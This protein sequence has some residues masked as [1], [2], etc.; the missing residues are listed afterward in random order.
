MNQE[1]HCARE[2]ALS[3][4]KPS[5][6]DIDHGMELH[7][8]AVVI[9]AYGFLPFGPIM[10]SKLRSVADAGASGLELEDLAEEM[11]MFAVLRDAECLAECLQAWKAAGVTCIFQNA[12]HGENSIQGLIKRLAG[13]THVTDCLPDAIRRATRPDDILVSKRE[14]AHCLYMSAN[15]VPLPQEWNSVEEGLRFI[16]IFFQLGVRMMHLT[17]NR[18]N[19][20]GDG[21]AE[22]ANAGLSAFGRDAIAEMN[23]I[24]VIVD[25]AHSGWST[26]L[27]TAKASD[28]PVVAS[29]TACA[30]LYH[31]CRAK[32]DEIIRAIADKNGYIGICCIPAF[33][34]GTGDI[35]AFLD[36]IDYA[37][38]RFGVEHVAIGTDNTW[39]SRRR[40][41]SMNEFQFPKYRRPYWNFWPPDSGLDE[42]KWNKPRQTQSLSW[43]NWPMF[44]VGLVQRGYSDEEIMKILGGNVLRVLQ[45]EHV[46]HS[47]RVQ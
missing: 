17:Y 39:R 9:D 24:G 21:C 38:K 15:G 10:P 19:A 34:G 33:L 30:G 5:R 1:M 3:L 45:D 18:R 20:L 44:T 23:R 42:G 36:H 47:K 28:G 12:G 14:K 41:E 6:K 13:F 31:H 37:A 26:G 29:H 40:R 46:S 7:S 11:D 43:I 35:R 32:P 22:A 25:V 16:R 2:A 27:E 4:L 8:N